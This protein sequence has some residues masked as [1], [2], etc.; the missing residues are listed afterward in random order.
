M[1]PRKLLLNNERQTPLACRWDINDSSSGSVIADV[2]LRCLPSGD[3]ALQT[4]G[5]CVPQLFPCFMPVC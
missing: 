1:M 4:L 3:F 5:Q 2:H